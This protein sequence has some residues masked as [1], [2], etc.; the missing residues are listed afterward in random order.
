MFI[1][2]EARTLCI[3]DG[4]DQ[5]LSRA[6][7]LRPADGRVDL[8][9]QAGDELVVHHQAHQLADDIAL[10]EGVT[11]VVPPRRAAEE[12]LDGVQ[13][14]LLHVG[15][16]DLRLL[17]VVCASYHEKLS[18]K[19]AHRDNKMRTRSPPRAKNLGAASAGAH[20][21]LVSLL[22]N[23]RTRGSWAAP[24]GLRDRQTQ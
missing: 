14:S 22:R 17:P 9:S 5:L 10:I 4:D 3:N 24:L 20:G 15:A 19:Q 2:E 11:E 16:S 8:A 23:S 6:Q 13:R 18:A 7:R 1:R 21:L 12:L